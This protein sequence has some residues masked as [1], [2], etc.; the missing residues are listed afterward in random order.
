LDYTLLRKSFVSRLTAVITGTARAPANDAVGDIETPVYIPAG[1]RM[2]VTRDEEDIETP[3][4]IP[5]GNKMV[6]TRD[7]EGNN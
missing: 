3:V 5:A 1:N 7:V 2:V 6:V 4:Y